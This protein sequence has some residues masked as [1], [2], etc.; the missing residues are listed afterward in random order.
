MLDREVVI[1]TSRT[2]DLLDNV[3]GVL[4]SV[5]VEIVLGVQVKIDAMISKSFHISP[6]TRLLTALG[7]G[8]SHVSWVFPNDV[9]DGSFIL[10]HLLLTHVGCDVGQAVMGPGVRGDLMALSNHATDDGWIRLGLI[11]WSFM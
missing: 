5:R 7:V 6:A 2:Q 4:D 8:G 10:D 9:G 1:G 3:L 11:N